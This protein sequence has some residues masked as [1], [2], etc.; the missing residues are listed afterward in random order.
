MLTLVLGGHAQGKLKAAL[1]GYYNQPVLNDEEVSKL[2]ETENLL[3]MDETNWEIGIE[4]R[5]LLVINHLHLI[6][7]AFVK[8]AL[9]EEDQ[10]S[11]NLEEQLTEELLSWVNLQL[12]DSNNAIVIAD[13][14]GN[15]IVP[16]EREARL[17]REVLGRVLIVLAKQAD[18]VERV[19]C[20]ISQKIK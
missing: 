14:I 12:A 5:E 3:Y 6:A 19:V 2:L 1:S 18:C 11:L 10:N 8:R 9:S 17:L 4:G 20:Q 13:E 16:M 7:K 15:G